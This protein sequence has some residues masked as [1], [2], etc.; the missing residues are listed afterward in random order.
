MI[1]AWRF[2]ELAEVAY[3]GD[4][5]SATWRCCWSACGGIVTGVAARACRSWSCG[6]CSRVDRHHASGAMGRVRVAGVATVAARVRP[7][8]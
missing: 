1:C 8:A 6:W 2:P 7:G 4:R 5:L 3:D